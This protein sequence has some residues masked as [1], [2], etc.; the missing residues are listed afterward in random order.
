MKKE[1]SKPQLVVHGDVEKLT[2][3]TQTGTA[4]DKTFPAGTPL[5]ELTIS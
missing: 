4:L 1:Y 2:L 5:D 3:Q